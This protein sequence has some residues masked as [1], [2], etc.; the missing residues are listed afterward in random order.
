MMSGGLFA[1]PTFFLRDFLSQQSPRRAEMEGHMGLSGMK[2]FC[3]LILI[4]LGVF[5]AQSVM[6]WEVAR[7]L[8]QELVFETAPEAI[9]AALDAV[10][11]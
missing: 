6:D 9:T 8:S 11:R 1:P 7:T 2:W 5:Y 4:G 3:C 10:M